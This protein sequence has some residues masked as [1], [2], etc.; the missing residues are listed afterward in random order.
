M[1]YFRNIPELKSYI[2]DDIREGSLSRDYLLNVL[3]YIR[4]DIYNDLYKEYKKIKA[5]R[6][7]NKWTNYYVDFPI[8]V[9]D[10]IKK[11]NPIQK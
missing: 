7:Y 1:S 11:Y 4:G 6:I 10:E 9:K 2:P 3:F 8:G 5:S